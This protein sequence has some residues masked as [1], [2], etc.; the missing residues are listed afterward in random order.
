MKVMKSKKPTDQ[1]TRFNDV[2]NKLKNLEVFD[3]AIEKFEGN[4]SLL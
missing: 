4:Y 2:V 3:D 1:Y